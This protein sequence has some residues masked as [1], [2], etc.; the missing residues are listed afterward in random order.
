MFYA[1]S[2]FVV[3]ALF[4]L[5]SLAVWALHGLAAWAVSGAGALSGAASAGGVFALPDG[6]ARWLPPELV[7]AA[8]AWVA[9]LGPVVDSLLQAAPALAGAL[10]VAAWVVWTLGG[11]LL[12]LLGA[13]L[14]LLIALSRRGRGGR[15]GPSAGRPLATG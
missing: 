14:H 1:L 15:P 5:W 4:A 8:G 10:A 12:L 6:W 2:W 11:L 9:D 7:Q 13:G 3:L